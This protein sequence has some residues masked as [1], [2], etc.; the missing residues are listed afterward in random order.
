M[1]AYRC[2]VAA[3]TGPARWETVDAISQD[4]LLARLRSL[5]LTAL[6]V[7]G[8]APTLVDR[9]NA[10]VS[11]GSRPGIAEQALILTQLAMLVRSGMPVDRSVDLLRD[12]APRAGQ[13]ALLQAVLGDIREGRSLG[14]ALEARGLFPAYVIGVIRAAERAGRLADAL[15]S[16][17]TRMTA[18]AATRRALV[19]ALTY[20]AAVLVA[21]LAALALVLTTVVPQFAPVF[22]GNEVRLPTLTRGV[23]AMSAFVTGHGPILV[24]LI[25][26]LPVLLIAL[27]RSVAGQSVIN[28]YRRYIPGMRLR[29]QYLA[30]Q[31]TGLLGTLTGNGVT[32]VAAL[33]L[34]RGAIASARWRAHLVK[35]EQGVREGQSLSASLGTADLMPRTAIRLIEVGERGGQL[36]ATCAQASMIMGDAAQARIERIVALANPVAIIALGGVVAMLVGGVMLG[37]FALGDFA[38]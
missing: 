20:P 10:P 29:D 14:V 37:I 28:R 38:G 19:T 8:G 27:L 9:L 33:P 15:T 17:A 12:Q 16:L 5:G 7:R 31:L 6:D 30:A 34:A 2:L 32:V 4:A 36:A 11:L 21:T 22:E 18:V 24:L 3:A 26:G 13:R 23:L 25:L 35:V 1:T